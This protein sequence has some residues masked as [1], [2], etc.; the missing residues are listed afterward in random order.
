MQDQV[1]IKIDIKGKQ[2]V[3]G[4]KT[5]NVSGESLVLIG[6]VISD[7]EKK[8][9][10]DGFIVEIDGLKTPCWIFKNCPEV[11]RAGCPAF[12]NHGYQCMSVMKTLCKGV[13]QDE[14]LKKLSN[15]NRCNFVFDGNHSALKKYHMEFDQDGNPL[16]K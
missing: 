11:R 12:P 16:A 3:N 6:E 14:M 4:E 10:V 15:C 7:E 5:L 13:M 9:V 2:I 8:I 1:K